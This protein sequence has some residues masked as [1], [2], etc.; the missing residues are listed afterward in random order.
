M[1]PFAG[2]FYYTLKCDPDSEYNKYLISCQRPCSY[3]NSC[4]SI[5]RYY[6]LTEGAILYLS[7][8]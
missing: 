5:K 1:N 8:I 2:L 3:V 4:V 6:T 7:D